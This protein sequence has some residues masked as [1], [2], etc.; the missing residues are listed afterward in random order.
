MSRALVTLQSPSDRAKVARWAAGC[1]KG[2]R[3]EF[4]G[5]K[6]TLPQNDR[7]W[8]L[9]TAV[10]DQL[11]WHGQ[12]YAASEWKDYFMHAYRG[13]KWMPFEDGGMIPIGRSTSGLSKAEHCEF[14]ALIEAFCARHDIALP[15]VEGAPHG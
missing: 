8:L 14:T 4:R 13:E 11:V 15:W 3:V 5:P 10:A 6:R 12:K 7:Q 1:T 9:L 2:T